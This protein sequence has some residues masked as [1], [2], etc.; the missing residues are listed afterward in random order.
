MDLRTVG[1]EEEFFLI[2]PGTGRLKAVS[3]QTVAAHATAVEVTQEMFLEQIET[4]TRPCLTADE[5]LC[6]LRAGRR[7]VGEAAAAAGARVIAAGTHPL[8]RDTE[9]VTPQSR[10]KRIEALGGETARQSQL[11]A[12]HVHV[13]VGDTS[14]GVRVI[15]RIRPWLPLLLALSVNS[16]YWEGRDTSFAS[17]R[18]QMITRWPTA[19]PA[20]AFEGADLYG[21]VAERM[22][23]WGAA[24][25]PGMLYFDARLSHHLPT[26]EIRVADV[27]TEPEHAVL[28]A[29][30]TRALVT[31]M[32]QP[33]E[34]LPV[35]GW[36][37]SDLLRVATWRCARF[38]LG[39]DQVHP[40][41]GQLAP[42]RTIVGDLVTMLRP[43]LDQAGDTERVVDLVERLLS[44]GSGATRQRRVFER[45][46]ELTAV[47]YDL[48]DRTEASWLTA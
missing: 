35:P 15:D 16:P 3:G 13:A 30:L 43:T 48:A 19:G 37:R 32:A 42:V 23:S 26:V 4:S 47:V 29:L 21:E 1:V 7:A 8:V 17:W 45:T 25:D 12:M 18:S 44:G 6:E 39:V 33:T 28:V 34:R 46:R 40:C 2:D 27:C 11:C 9:A 22:K 41:N 24:H 14:E 10:Y 5:L 20:E 36:W 31:A 38:G